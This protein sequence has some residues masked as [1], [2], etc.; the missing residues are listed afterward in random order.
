MIGG[1]LAILGPLVIGPLLTRA[2]TNL[3]P[4][5]PSWSLPLVNGALQFGGAYAT[6]AWGVNPLEPAQ[7]ALISTASSTALYE[8]ASKRWQ[9]LKPAKSAKGVTSTSAVRPNPWD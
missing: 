1:V 5:L 8:A 4:K 6:S 3:A 9:W 7:A 2:A